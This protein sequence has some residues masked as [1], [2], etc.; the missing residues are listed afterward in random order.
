M[1]EKKVSSRNAVGIC[2][3]WIGSARFDVEDEWG[4]GRARRV[5]KEKEKQA[6][7][8]AFARSPKNDKG[9]RRA[10]GPPSSP[11]TGTRRPRRAPKRRP[12]LLRRRIARYRGTTAPGGLSRIERPANRA[13]TAQPSRKL[14][15]AGA[16]ARRVL[17]NRAAATPGLLLFQ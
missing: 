6:A 2:Q 14:S 16:C 3:V 5:F 4:K 7:A 13:E 17:K 9:V 12:P 8:A 11:A 15:N 1:D 10:L